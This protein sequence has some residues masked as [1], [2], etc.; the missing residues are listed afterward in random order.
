MFAHTLRSTRR[1]HCSARAWVGVL[2]AFLAIG[3]AAGGQEAGAGQTRAPEKQAT[4][5]KSTE[6]VPAQRIPRQ[7]ASTSAAVD[8]EVRES[9]SLN[10]TRPVA[11]AQLTLHN[12]QTGRIVRASTSA[13]GVFRV[14]LL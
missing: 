11:V 9:I 3:R 4:L 14:L 7:Q 2:L 13:E 10:E 12:L 5:E 1:A 6:A 8:G